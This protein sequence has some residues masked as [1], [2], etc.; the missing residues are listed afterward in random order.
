MILIPIWKF[1]RDKL[2]ID[3][4]RALLYLFRRD[5][6]FLFSKKNYFFVQKTVKKKSH[7]ISPTIHMKHIKDKI[8]IGRTKIE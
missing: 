8:E 6:I 7:K 1:F 4:T 5:I 3:N 2:E